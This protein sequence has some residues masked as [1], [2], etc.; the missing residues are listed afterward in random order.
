M[1]SIGPSSGCRQRLEAMRDWCR[2]P[3]GEALAVAEQQVLCEI[4]S[5]VFGY[6]LVVLDPACQPVAMDASRILHR[7]VQTCTDYGLELQ[8]TLL[9]LAE[10][11]P[12][13]ADS[14]DAFVLPHVLETARDPHQVL[15]EIDRCLLAE[16]HLIVLSLNPYGWWGVRKLLFGWRGSVPWSLRFVSMPRLKDWLSLLGFDTIQ[17]RYLFP[18]P[19]WLYGRSQ[20]EGGL[21]Q[22]LHHESWPLLAASYVLVA[23]KRVATLTQIKPRWRP[24]RAVLAG[25]MPETGQGNVSRHG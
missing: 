7:V 17:Y 3:L 11:L 1:E 5:D 4:L 22:R 25:S 10:N 15:R 19:P 16:G 9:G 18:H 21:L 6:H 23:R 24:R 12:M 20:N 2:Q 8:P 14:V 13:Q